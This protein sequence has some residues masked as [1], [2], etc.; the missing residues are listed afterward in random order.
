MWQLIA[1]VTLY[2]LLFILYKGVSFLLLFFFLFIVSI[3]I[4]QHSTEG[5]YFV[6]Y[7][8]DNLPSKHHHCGDDYK[9]NPISSSSFTFGHVHSLNDISLVRFS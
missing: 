8:G 3:G 9:I 2:A 5:I 1:H 4:P 6:T 7:P